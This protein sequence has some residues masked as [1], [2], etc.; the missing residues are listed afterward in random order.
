MAVEE[1]LFRNDLRGRQ[2]MKGTTPPWRIQLK[3]RVDHANQN[4]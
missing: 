2:Q 3:A 4:A 1:P